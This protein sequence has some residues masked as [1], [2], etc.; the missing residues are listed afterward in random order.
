VKEKFGGSKDDLYSRYNNQM[1]H[2]VKNV[3][4]FHPGL[5]QKRIIVFL[6]NLRNN[7]WGATF[8]FNAG[9]IT[10]AIDDASSGSCSTCFF[11]YCSLHPCG[12]TR[13]PNKIQIMWFLY[14]AFSYQEE[15]NTIASH[16][17]IPNQMKWH[18]PFG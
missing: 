9:D 7:H 12:T 11:C 18:S 17:S 4:F 16:V 3:L 6:T 13:I 1:I 10:A 14:L 2:V 8:V 5:L 15:L